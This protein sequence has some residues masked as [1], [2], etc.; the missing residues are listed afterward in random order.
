LLKQEIRCPCS[1]T[2]SLSTEMRSLLVYFF[3]IQFVHSSCPWGFAL[4]RD[5]ECRGNYT[6]INTFQDEALV[7]IIAKCEEIQGQPIIIHDEDDQSFWRNHMSTMWV[8]MGLTCNIHSQLWE[9]SDGSALDFKPAVGYDTKLDE[10]CV[11]A[12]TWAM[13]SDGGWYPW[14]FGDKAIVTDVYCTV[15]LQQPVPA[16]DG[17]DG[18]ADDSEDGVCYQV[19]ETAENWQEAQMNCKTIGANLASV[20]NQQENAF[21][22]R[23]AVSNGAVNGLFLGASL[24]GKGKDFGWVDGSDWDYE[25]FHQGFPRTGFGDCLA[26]DTSISTGQWM[27]M[28]C[29]AKLPVACIRDQKAV[30]QPSCGP[31]PWDEGTIITS[32]GFPY[33]A[34]TFCDYFLSVEEGKKVEVE[35]VFLEANACC[36]SLV[37]YDGYLGASVLANLTGELTNATFTTTSSNIM[38][39]NWQP[40]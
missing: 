28:D 20:H 27:N 35:I 11:P 12:Y 2:H 1:I 38:R 10:P 39:V 16:D 29:A 9:W 26:M 5:G 13:N 19:G 6:R 7:A 37:L 30:V 32:P 31:G 18:F 15:Q 33:S 14:I 23:L 40:N 21:I 24:S 3:I 17:C 22:R 36:D 4:V 8:S 34:S 25:N